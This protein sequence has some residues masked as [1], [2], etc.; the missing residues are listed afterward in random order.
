MAAKKWGRW[1]EERPLG[2]NSGQGDTFLV[3]KD[4]DDRRDLYVLK[5]M[6][7]KGPFGNR[8]A[9]FRNEILAGMRLEHPNVTRVTDPELDQ[10]KPFVVTEYC[11]GGALSPAALSGRTLL[12]RVALFRGICA[13]VA[14]AHAAGVVHR[15]LKPD[16]IFLRPDGNPVV[17]DFGLCYLAEEGVDRVTNPDEVVG[18]RGFMA[19]ECEGGRLEVVQPSMDV[20]SLGK[21]L[22]W[23]LAG[24]IFIRERHRASENDLSRDPSDFGMRL[25]FE[26]L[27]RTVVEDITQRLPDA[28][29]L[30]TELDA[31]TLRIAARRRMTELARQPISL[32]GSHEVKVAS[33]RLGSVPDWQSF[34][35]GA[36]NVVGFTGYGQVFAA[37]AVERSEREGGR[38]VAWVGAPHRGWQ[39]LPIE[40]S[41]PCVPQKAGHQGMCADERGV[42]L[43]VVSGARPDAAATAHIVRLR[44]NANPVVE[45]LAEG[46]ASPMHYAVATG[47]S[48]RVAAYIGA[49]SP[50]V[51]DAMGLTILRDSAGEHRHLFSPHTNFPAPL[52]ISGDG[53]LHQAVVLS[54]P[55]GKHETRQLRYLHKPPGKEWTEEVIDSTAIRGAFGEFT[56]D[57][58]MSAHI[59]LSLSAS[60]SP[61]IV[62]SPKNGPPHALVIFA[63]EGNVF[64]RHEIDIRPI[65][66]SF[67]FQAIDTSSTKQIV[68]DEKGCGHVALYSDAGE[69]GA[70]IYVALDEEWRVVDQRAFPAREFFG[71]GR[72]ST[73]YIYLALR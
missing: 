5:Q 49:E 34:D 11:A 32:S 45:T 7:G 39:M 70:V 50:L 15:D 72:D 6:K 46:V 38:C 17:G 52:A 61:V 73:G 14:H 28:G 40:I 20:Y 8:V 29:S 42:S 9:R 62:A 51:P 71:M 33:F 41:N 1:V 48:G 44:P 43:L 31:M 19:P 58:T 22:Y 55:A 2:S 21:I 60:G 16:N 68:F 65:A 13:G 4:G 24:R 23:I 27:D 66:K 3:Y 64:R 26:L 47:P 36:A 12:E 18:A 69:L 37:W 25:V 53:G 59:H 57:G 35:P 10:P 67:G 63:K 30:V 54:L 56:A